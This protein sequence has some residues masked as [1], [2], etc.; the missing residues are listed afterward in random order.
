MLEALDDDDTNNETHVAIKG[1][2]K[3][4]IVIVAGTYPQTKEGIREESHTSYTSAS[5]YGRC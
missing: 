2:Y 1:N 4:K 3:L 5:W